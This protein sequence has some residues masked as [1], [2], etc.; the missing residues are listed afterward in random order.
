MSIRCEDE[1]AGTTDY[2]NRRF[3]LFEVARVTLARIASR[4]PAA[5]GCLELTLEIS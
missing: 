4:I 1:V 2:D 5:S 3:R